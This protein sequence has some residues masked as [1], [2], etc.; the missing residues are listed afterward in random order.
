MAASFGLTWWGKQWLNAL[1]N[2]DYSNRLPRGESYARKG[3]V[4]SI[5]ISGNTILAK[6]KGTG[7]KPYTVSIL[8]P[9]FQQVKIDKLVD[10]ILEHPIVLS[11]LLNREL[12]PMIIDI[13]DSLGMQIF[14]DTW[15]Y[16]TMSC[17]CPDDAV[18]CKHLAA[19]IYMLSREIDNNPFLVFT[20]HGIDFDKELKARGLS[21]GQ[22]KM[23]NIPSYK[24]L[25]EPRK[26]PKDVKAVDNNDVVVDFSR[27]RDITDPLVS[28][29]EPNPPF[30][31]NGD[32][33]KVYHE[34]MKNLAQAAG[35]FLKEVKESESP[36]TEFLLKDDVLHVHLD[37][38]YDFVLTVNSV[39]KKKSRVYP[40]MEKL[41]INILYLNV[42]YLDE[43]DVTVS[44]MYKLSMAALNLL[45]NGCVIPQ[46]VSL[47]K[48]EYYIRWIP[49][50]L[51]NEVKVI[52]E[53]LRK[54][55]PDDILTIPSVK[56]KNEIEVEDAATHLLSYMI[57]GFVSGLTQLFYPFYKVCRLFF[58][59]D[60]FTFS[61]IG[62]KQVPG[63]IKSWLDRLH[64]STTQYKP[65]LMV[66]EGK[67]D[68]FLIDFFVEY[69]GV[70][71]PLKKV[72]SLKKYEK[73]RISILREIS[74][75][76]SF[77]EGLEAYIN[78]EAKSP[79]VF[80]MNTF[81]PF[82]TNIIPAVKLLGIKVILPKS[83]QE[84][85]RPRPSMVVSK[86]VDDGKRY[87]RLDDLL[88]FDWQVALGDELMSE[89][90]FAKLME[91]ARGLIKFK[92]SYIY[93][94]DDDLAR[95]EKAFTSSK[96]LSSGQILQ[97][98]LSESYDKTKVEI[99]SEV[100]RLMQELTTYSDIPVPDEINA[101]LR[102]YQERGY[103]WM[104]R[105]MRIGF[106]SI[107]ADDMGL[108]K[109]L[110]V[111]TLLQKIK[112]EGLLVKKKAIVVVPTGLIT[113][114]QSEIERFASNLSVFIYHGQQR[115][116]T[117]FNKDILL[118]TYGVLRSDIDIIKKKKW[119]VAVIDEAQ[120]IKNANTTQSKAVRSLTAETCI[121]MSGTPVENRLS[122]FWSVMDF[123]NKG[124]LGTL[125]SFNDDYVKPIQ[126]LGDKQVIENFR[127]VTAPFMMRRLKT[128]KNIINDLPDKVEQ[129]EM[130]YLT[131]IQASLYKETLNEAMRLIEN[132]KDSDAKS[133]FKRRGLILQMILALK[134]ICNHPALFLKNKKCKPDDSGKVMM[135]LDLLNS[136]VDSGQK[137]LVFT[138]FK[139]MGTILEQ[140][141]FEA[142]GKRPLFLHGGCSVKERKTMV[143]RFQ[144]NK[145]DQIFL[146]SLK[147]AGTGLNL[148]AASHVIHFD[149]WWNPAVE[150]QATDRAYRI[151]QHQNVLVHRFIAKNTFEERINAMIQQKKELADMTIATGE[152]WIGDL[153]NKEL[154]ELFG[155]E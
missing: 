120:N 144:N 132:I 67:N 112:N 150:A 10:K 29:L 82:L 83:L 114:W 8:S 70:D 68:T 60:S 108:G 107:I 18:P 35:F 24:S 152:S 1:S 64:I 28:I 41:P 131:D 96:P 118:T 145:G 72:F 14:P 59:D 93:V 119:Q 20:I 81:A 16:F 3:N 90:D 6:V 101:T 77:V 2:I 85:I 151:G 135:L 105:N 143:E 123:T 97:A 147:A 86:K 48:N 21:L 125:K 11:Q 136:I 87:L 142:M 51:D 141:I 138:Q 99:T 153:S 92:N 74:L 62:E 40:T 75:L 98:A 32:F 109:T 102:P 23:E 140:I 137:V 54:I 49:A 133:L 37:K 19:V 52:V 110:Q 30:Y 15:R 36:A 79:I 111:I 117:S 88:K 155:R 9:R 44:S 113:N 149:L 148:T 116:F 39:E 7:V 122:E 95:L 65:S 69:K 76:T 50:V 61:S 139:E 22:A 53:T 12:N 34:V 146:L 121:A 73:E 45:A 13:C 124:Y 43:Y 71:V 55:V 100:R 46:L 66:S 103:S 106:G 56:D 78:D 38:N 17:S 104:Y 25:F 27:L 31:I 94:H 47:G 80:D 58:E 91:N 33:Q 127:K 5:D 134:Q 63:S 89:N 130:V 126:G 26:E 115:D 129:D 128:D 42:D 154:S 57:T 84:L 4:V